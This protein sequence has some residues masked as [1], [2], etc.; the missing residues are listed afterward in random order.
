MVEGN[1]LDSFRLKRIVSRE[2]SCEGLRL[3]VKCLEGSQ[4]W[5]TQIELPPGKPAV[6]DSD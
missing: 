2:T 1:H 6:K 3:T 4:P 5:R